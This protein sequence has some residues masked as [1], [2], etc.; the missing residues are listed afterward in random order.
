M[1]WAAPLLVL[2]GVGLLIMSICA[3]YIRLHDELHDVAEHGAQMRSLE[4][5]LRRARLFRNALVMA[6]V[7][8][9]LLVSGGLVLGASAALESGSAAAD[10]VGNILAFVGVAVLLAS[11]GFLVLEATLSFEVLEA[12]ASRL[13]QAR[14]DQPQAEE[15]GGPGDASSRSL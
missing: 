10:L 4:L 5:L 9:M 15:P 14:E 12:D 8:V 1:S 7:S 11:S 3:R 2:P 6:Y 13:M